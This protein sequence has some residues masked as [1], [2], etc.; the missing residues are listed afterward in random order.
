MV[1]PT[2]HPKDCDLLEVGKNEAITSIFSKPHPA[3]RRCRNLNNAAIYIFT[4]Q[5][6]TV[7][8]SNQPSDFGRDV[9]PDIVDKKLGILCAYKS[10]EYLQDMGTPKRLKEVEADVLSGRYQ[11]GL[12]PAKENDFIA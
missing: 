8:K 6:F 12:L 10:N 11:L 4:P 9:F 2:N 7:I 1:Q 3:G 5:I